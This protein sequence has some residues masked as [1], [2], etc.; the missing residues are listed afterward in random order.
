MLVR[1]SC[2]QFTKV[3]LRRSTQ[4]Y[5]RANKWTDKTK[6]PLRNNHNTMLNSI[7]FKIS[8][9]MCALAA[10]LAIAQASIENKPVKVTHHNSGP[11]YDIDE[12]ERTK[13]TPE[14]EDGQ[15]L[16][17]IPL[18]PL[19]QPSSP[20]KSNNR[21]EEQQQPGD[22][23]GP[24]VGHINIRRIFLI[25]MS[26][27]SQ[28]DDTSLSNIWSSGQ[29]SMS[30]SSSRQFHQ[31]RQPIEDDSTA[32]TW[33]FMSLL[34]TRHVFGADQASRGPQKPEE[35][36]SS[37]PSTLFTDKTPMNSEREFESTP[38][39]GKQPPFDPIRMMIEMMQQALSQ[40]VMTPNGPFQDLNKEAAGTKLTDS[41]NKAESSETTGNT[42][43]N[44]VPK[45]PNTELE[46]PFKQPLSNNST[47]EEIV[48]LDGKKYLKKTV[49]NRHVGENIIFMTKRLLFV[50]LNETSS[51]DTNE[52]K[53]ENTS[54]TSSEEVRKAE[55]SSTSPTEAPSTTT[56]TTEASTTTTVASTTPSEAPSSTTTSTTTTTTT[57]VPS[58]TSTLSTPTSEAASEA[59]F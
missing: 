56:S 35:S 27:P 33:P 24:L 6:V 13:L 23:D 16:R 8:L 52:N 50:P 29:P 54:P 55:T 53:G 38:E 36:L 43:T 39:T 14:R 15:I 9:Y 48:E 32:P 3:K 19:A 4:F 45:R 7:S 10:L 46:Q 37:R 59:S 17:R 11:S 40:A 1:D 28:D 31:D 26:P 34:P 44:E 18:R 51:V 20:P 42:E 49:V 5:T 47:K 12:V 22:N 57:E 25:P 58:T 30:A 2:E 21:E 41:D